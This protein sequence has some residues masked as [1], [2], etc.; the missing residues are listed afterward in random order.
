MRR[1]VQLVA[2]TC[3]ALFIVSAATP[4]AAKGNRWWHSGPASGRWA[5]SQVSFTGTCVPPSL[6]LGTLPGKFRLTDVVVGTLV[7]AQVH[8]QDTA[9]AGPPPVFMTRLSLVVLPGTFS[10][11]F[12]TP[13]VL[14]PGDL[15][16]GCDQQVFITI[17]G[18]QHVPN[19]HHEEEGDDGDE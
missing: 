11:S 15:M 14:A 3:A 4:A 9:M 12:R 10:E 13:L 8:I 5:S 2:V 18:W 16:V 6:L 7:L 17:S 19:E 1:T